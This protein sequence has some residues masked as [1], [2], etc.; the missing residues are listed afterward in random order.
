MRGKGSSFMSPVWIL[1]FT[2]SPI[3]E[4]SGETSVGRFL[5]RLSELVSMHFLCQIVAFLPT[6]IKEMWMDQGFEW[7]KDFPT[8]AA[9]DTS[10]PRHLLHLFQPVVPI[11]MCRVAYLCI[12]TLWL[13]LYIPPL[14]AQLRFVF[15]YL[16][17]DGWQQKIQWQLSI[18][19]NYIKGHKP[20][21]EYTKLQFGWH[22]KHD[23]VN[24]IIFYL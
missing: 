3:G 21:F 18:L 19:V 7:K 10:R 11:S 6:E 2:F 5:N 12:I 24:F 4:A 1:P 15:L 14:G 20:G 17:S 9:K 23:F 22:R 8:N 13:S 16:E